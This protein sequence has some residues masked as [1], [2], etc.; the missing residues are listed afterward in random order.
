MKSRHIMVA[1]TYMCFA[2]SIASRVIGEIE[3]ARELEHMGV[4]AAVLYYAKRS[5]DKLD[6]YLEVKK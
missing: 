3:T 2:F 4:I 1:I 6:E 5:N